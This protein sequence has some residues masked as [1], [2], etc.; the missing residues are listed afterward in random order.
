M[1]E[2]RRKR[3]ATGP[4][5]DAQIVTTNLHWCHKEM[6]DRLKK[7]SVK[8]ASPYS[9]EGAAQPTGRA[10]TN[11]L[12][13]PTVASACTLSTWIQT[14]KE[15]SDSVKD[16]AAREW[17]HYIGKPQAG[18]LELAEPKAADCRERAANV[19]KVIHKGVEMFASS[20][21]H[22]P[23]DDA[24]MLEQIIMADS[25]HSSRSTRSKKTAIKNL[26]SELRLASNEFSLW[27]STHNSADRLSTERQFYPPIIAFFVFVGLVSHALDTC[28]LGEK[29]RPVPFRK[30]L[31]CHSTDKMCEDAQ[32]DERIDIGLE[33]K[34]IG[35]ASVGRTFSWQKEKVATLDEAIVIWYS[36]LFLV[37][38][39]KRGSTKG[40]KVD[41]IQQLFL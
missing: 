1:P 9:A 26:A 23:P 10:R 27:T 34:S 40:D 24:A 25:V 22:I 12:T 4:P 11:T 29:A 38:E 13:Q 17:E 35:S 2:S 21:N 33:T 36:K 19:S 30:I 16:E 39:V 32:S 6:R 18:V 41:A 3:K 37:I 5:E 15:H 20:S 8:P 28:S 31:P 7:K 14:P